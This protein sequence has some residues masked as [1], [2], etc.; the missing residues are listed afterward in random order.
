[1]PLT[2]FWRLVVALSAVV[3]IGTCVALGLLYAHFFIVQAGTM[4]V[5]ERP[6][7]ERDV[8]DINAVAGGEAEVASARFLAIYEYTDYYA[9]QGASAD[10]VCLVG[11]AITTGDYWELCETMADSREVIG[12]VAGPDGRNVALVPDQFDHGQLEA[13]G[14]VTL[15][16]NLL[17]Q[18]LAPCKAPLVC[19]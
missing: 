13:D 3:G 10:D 14:W 12:F 9:T 15:H 17:V 8:L 19:R 16:Q 6:A 2:L 4:A 5:L 1:V 11:Q 18:P 7:T